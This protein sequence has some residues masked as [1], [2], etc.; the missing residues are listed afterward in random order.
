MRGPRFKKRRLQT[1]RR[2]CVRCGNPHY[3]GMF[4]K[5]RRVCMACVMLEDREHG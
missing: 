3:P 5:G 2:E 1:T 4:P